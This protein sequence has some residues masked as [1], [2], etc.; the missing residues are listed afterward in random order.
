MRKLL[1]VAATLA[2][3]GA[4]PVAAQEIG[5]FASMRG[6]NQAAPTNLGL[7]VP[8][9]VRF[10]GIGSLGHQIIDLAYNEGADELYGITA[11]GDIYL[12]DR[13]TAETALLTRLEGVDF[14]ALEY[15]P[16][17][18]TLFAADGATLYAVDSTLGVVTGTSA[19]HL[20]GSAPDGVTIRSLAYDTT[21]GTMFVNLAGAQQGIDV[22]GLGR[23]NVETGTIVFVGAYRIDEET[24]EDVRAIV[25]FPSGS[26]WGTRLVGPGATQIQV[27][28]RATGSIITIGD[29][30]SG[31]EVLGL[32]A[33]PLP[34]PTSTESPVPTATNSPI[35]TPTAS[36]TPTPSSTETATATPTVTSSLTRTPTR[37]PPS[38]RTATASATGTATATPIQC[39]G[40]CNGDGRVAVNEIVTGANIALGELSVSACPAMDR[41]SDRDVE[42]FELIN[43]VNNAL[44]GCELPP[45]GRGG[46]SPLRVPVQ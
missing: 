21:I 16:I 20:F 31:G 13:R 41:N 42:I 17:R 33:V 11:A 32:A 14:S 27:I 4:S 26:L 25:V 30:P 8:G 28:D 37:T 5:L 34:T 23:L 7:F 10:A 2:L 6:S 24:L 9:D 35:A 40:D 39:V 45:A 29:I 38:T 22:H 12:I 44:G 46:S 3:F 18:A 19:L 43:A 1:I 15:D 36:S